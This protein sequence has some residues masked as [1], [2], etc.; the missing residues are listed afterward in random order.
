[1]SVDANVPGFCTISRPTTAAGRQLNF[2]GLNGNSLH[3]DRLIDP[4]TLSTRAASV[5]LDFEAVCQT[6]HKLKVETQNNGLW[7]TIQTRAADGFGT[8][9]PY[10]L[11]LSW[12]GSNLELEADAGTR[13][14]HAGVVE[15]SRPVVGAVRMRLEVAPGATNAAANSPLQAGV[16]TDTI[17]I[18][19]EPAQ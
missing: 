7:Q 5:D 15:I 1:M 13:R 2:K 17:R 4:T 18:T 14:L 3:I 16:Y 10:T 19:L 11:L 12:G 8:A 6:P 9:I